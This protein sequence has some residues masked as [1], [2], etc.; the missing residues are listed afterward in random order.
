MRVVM[1]NK[2]FFGIRTSGLICCYAGPYTRA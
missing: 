1:V 2:G